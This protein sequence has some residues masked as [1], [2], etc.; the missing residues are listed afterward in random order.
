[1]KNW[2]TDVG[3]QGAEYAFSGVRMNL[4]PKEGGNRT[5][6]EA[7]AYGSQ[8]RFERNNLGDLQDPPYNF[9]YAPQQFF[10]DFNPTIGGPINQNKLWYFGS[11]SGNR[12]NNRILDTYFKPYEPSTPADCQDKPVDDPSQWCQADT[13]AVLNW[14][15]TIRITHQVTSRHKLRY[16][17][18]NTRLDDLRGNY[19]TGGLEASPEASW[20]LPLYPTWFAQVSYTAPLT[21]RLLIEA[22]YA[23]ER[24]DFRV[25]FQPANADQSR[26]EVGPSAR[27]EDNTTSA[28][29]PRE[30][31][32]RQGI[33]LLRHRVAL[34]QDRI[35]G[36]MGLRVQQNPYNADIL[37]APHG[38]RG[39]AG[40]IGHKRAL[41]EPDELSTSTVAPTSRISGAA[42]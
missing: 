6:I 19:T 25:K 3:A 40:C 29:Q 2:C 42:G 7:V 23:Y 15:E 24:G 39:A 21:N 1:M 37:R 28:T 17:F 34:D 41:A 8:E 33:A 4:I 16:S 12:S 14:S 11:V 36:S 35:R 5:T 9:Q 38:Q 18:D 32:E 26:L 31:E 13:G 30:E 27:L 10:F 22:G 20:N